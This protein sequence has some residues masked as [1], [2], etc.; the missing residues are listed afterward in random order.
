M[1]QLRHFSSG[2]LP[3]TWPIILRSAPAASVRLPRRQ[4]EFGLHAHIDV[5]AVTNVLH[6]HHPLDICVHIGRDGR[7]VI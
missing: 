3:E 2:N 7:E 1:M 6:I 5:V 4:V